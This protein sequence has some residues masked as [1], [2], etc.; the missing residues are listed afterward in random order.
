[1]S[2]PYPIVFEP[3]LKEKIWGGKRLGSLGKRVPPGQCIG[4][5]WE[6]ADLFSTSVSGGGGGS[7]H[8]IIASGPLAGRTIREAMTEWGARLCGEGVDA[9]RGFPLLVKLLDAKENLSVQ[10]HPSGAY[11]A[12]HWGCHLKTECWYILGAEPGSVIYKGIKEGVTRDE[13]AKA[14]ARGGDKVCDALISVPAVVGE[15]HNLP[16]GTC[17]ALG[18]GVLVAE[19]QT[20]SDTTFRVYD[21]GRPGR[22][23]HI[24]AALEC[25][26]FFPAPPAT[27][28]EPGAA[29]GRLVTTEY[30]QVDG[31][32][33][34][35]GLREVLATD[36]ERAVVVV[37]LSGRG[38]I[39]ALDCE[40]T[41]VA[42]GQTI[43]VPACLAANAG[44]FASTDAEVLLTRVGR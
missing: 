32:R 26:D 19:V 12:A 31:I 9:R 3:I 23:L 20:P 39:S 14:I 29:R 18:A 10:V 42:P 8:S 24:E 22:E 34:G 30:F 15:C 36:D 35:A 38:I 37:G 44:F 4:E 5:S 13:F 28:V 43:L 17:H 25:I 11:A 1:M 40:E 7:A 21:W 27:R 41:R 2:K 33:L 16:S 6:L